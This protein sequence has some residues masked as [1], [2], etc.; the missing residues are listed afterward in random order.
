M[1]MPS[2]L[3]VGPSW[4]GDTVLAQPLLKLVHARSGAPS[5]DVLAPPWT[6]PLIR[7]MPEVR[8]VVESPFAHGELN[9]T[10][11]R[12][13][14]RE[15]RG[16]AYDQAIVLPNSFKSALIP[17]LA[18]IPAR[19]GYLGEL[20]FGLLTDVRRVDRR[21]Q[22]QIAQRYAA[23]GL[24]RRDA[25]PDPLPAPG[26]T[27]DEA[28][29]QA[30]LARLGLDA[31][32]PAAALCPGAEYGPAKRWPARHFA[33]LA[34]ALAQRGC[35][36]WLIGSAR[37]ATLGAEITA[38]AEGACVNLCGATTLDEAVDLLAAAALVVS[39]DSGLMHVAAALGRPLIALYGSSSPTYTPPLSREARILS[40][41]LAC[42]PCFRREC[43]LGHF[44]CMV[45]LTPD[46]VLAEIDFDRISGSGQV[47][48]RANS[49][50]APQSPVRP[51]P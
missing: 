38:A 14:A 16:A 13:L 19:T 36:V 22:P 1:A 7:R 39:N 26:L 48:E 21:H 50:T 20:R 9:L 45:Q 2:V 28:G 41:A 18:G 47:A 49:A 44:N 3:V 10:G 11:R 15:L 8:R 23:L 51:Q 42:S 29:R 17:F 37:D 31:G 33:G 43:P 30:L 35:T 12:R 24:P 32:R 40:L 27:V 34:R 25:L 4:V 6:A 46:R 5:I